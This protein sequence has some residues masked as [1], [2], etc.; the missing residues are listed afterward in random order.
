MGKVLQARERELEEERAYI[1]RMRSQ[2]DKEIEGVHVAYNAQ[3]AELEAAET[4]RVAAAVA[5]ANAAMK[6]A[7]LEQRQQ[8]LASTHALMAC[9]RHRLLDPPPA[10]WSDQEL[11][12]SICWH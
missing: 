10:Y 4:E 6:K 2:L 11:S 9:E 7:E 12:K 3:V 5:S 8:H 1:A